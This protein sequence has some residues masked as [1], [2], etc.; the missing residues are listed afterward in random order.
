[1]HCIFAWLRS[2]VDQRAFAAVVGIAMTPDGVLVPLRWETTLK[3]T[4]WSKDVGK[5]LRSS[6][7]Q[8]SQMMEVVA[9]AYWQL[10]LSRDQPPIQRVG[11]R[12]M[13]FALVLMA[14]EL[15]SF[16][17]DCVEEARTR[18]LRQIPTADKADVLRAQARLAT[19][20]GSGSA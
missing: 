13:T 4:L 18:L 2:A 9:K 10:D 12:P 7:L 20:L 19:R 8:T 3:R 1:M 14:L 6:G 16:S 11:L 5:M 17:T 15:T